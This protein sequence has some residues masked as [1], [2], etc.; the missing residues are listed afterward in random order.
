MGLARY[1]CL[2][3]CEEVGSLRRGCGE[4][5][6]DPHGDH[7]LVC[8]NGRGG[9]MGAWKRSRHDGAR[10]ILVRLARQPASGKGRT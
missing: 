10:T 9:R 5:A 8:S 4:A 2:P 6:L 1:L 3:L 7:A